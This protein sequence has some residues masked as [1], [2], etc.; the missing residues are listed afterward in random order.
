MSFLSQ[1][2]PFIRTWDLHQG[3]CDLNNL[4]GWVL[5]FHINKTS[6]IMQTYDILLENIDLKIKATHAFLENFCSDGYST[7]IIEACKIAENLNI[8]SIIATT[9]LIKPQKKDSN[10]VFSSCTNFTVELTPNRS[11]VNC[12]TRSIFHKQLNEKQSRDQHKAKW[13][14]P[15]VR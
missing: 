2:S 11:I 15:T 1:P 9:S 3:C 4:R 14:I 6:K 10:A 12:R 5:L 13:N 8:N 7:A